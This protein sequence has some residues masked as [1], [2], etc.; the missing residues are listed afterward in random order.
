MTVIL[1]I[2]CTRAMFRSVK[3]CVAGAPPRSQKVTGTRLLLPLLPLPL[4]RLLLPLLLLP[5][6]AG[7]AA[8]CVVGPR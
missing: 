3:G 5:D 4:I 6:T 8:M 7:A 1:E 2:Y